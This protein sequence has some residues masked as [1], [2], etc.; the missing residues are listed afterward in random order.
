LDAIDTANRNLTE[1]VL[2][3]PKDTLEESFGEFQKLQ[4]SAAYKRGGGNITEAE[5]D[6]LRQEVYADVKS[7]VVIEGFE[8]AGER[9]KMYSNLKKRMSNLIL[10]IYR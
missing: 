8:D 6:K 9:N 4:T 5:K 10:C 7:I 1:Q 3:G 2:S